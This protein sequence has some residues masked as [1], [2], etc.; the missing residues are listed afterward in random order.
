MLLFYMRLVLSF[1]TSGQ[2]FWIKCDTY[3][4]YT[5]IVAGSRIA[6]VFLRSGRFFLKDNLF[7]A[8]YFPM[9][10]LNTK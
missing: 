6:A 9:S 8:V 1:C 10:S 7:L 4:T 3:F 2:V 5:F